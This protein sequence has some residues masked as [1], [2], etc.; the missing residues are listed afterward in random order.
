MPDLNYKKSIAW[1]ISWSLCF[2]V[3]MTLAKKISP[4]V[5]G[6]TLVFCRLAIGLAFA[7]PIFIGQGL[8][9]VVKTQSIWLHLIR[10]VVVSCSM[11]CTYYAYRNLPLADAAAI[12]QTGPL[13]TT[14]LAVLLLKE[15]MTVLKWLAMLVG[16]IGVLFIVKPGVVEFDSAILVALAAN[17]LAGLA[18]IMAKALSK[19]DSSQ[20]ILFYGT[21]GT[22]FLTSIHAFFYWQTP[23]KTDCIY[24][25]FI[26]AAGMLSQYC[27][28]QALKYAPASFVTPFEYIRLCVTIPIGMIVF[29]EMPDA[30]SLLGSLVILASIIFLVRKQGGSK[31]IS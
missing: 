4:D 27:Y 22:L 1:V 3:V 11:G 16:Y 9:C 12:G 13:F 7:M 5:P 8:M 14:L 23:S 31:E 17:L 18:I 15:S 30:Y 2:S 6:A 20:T 10:A 24:L 29:S 19:E 26:G 21:V 28:L 25:I